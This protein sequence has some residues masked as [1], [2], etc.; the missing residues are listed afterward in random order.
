MSNSTNLQFFFETMCKL[1]HF[2]QSAFENLKN[3]TSLE[4][5]IKIAARFC[6][7]LSDAIEVIDKGYREDNAEIIWKACHKVAGTSELLGFIDLGKKS[8]E[9]SK[10]L[11][12]LPDLSAYFFDLEKY[13][14]QLSLVRIEIE[15]AIPSWRE[16]L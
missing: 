5:C 8:K 14:T 4:V 1:N 12:A 16:Y 2:D 9:L 13:Q 11:Q 3:D 10:S 15:K 6:M 7:T